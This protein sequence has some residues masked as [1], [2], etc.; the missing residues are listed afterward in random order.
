MDMRGAPEK[1]RSNDRSYDEDLADRLWAVSED[2]T[3]VEYDFGR[4]PTPAEP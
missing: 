1:Q 4:L 3:G 2:E